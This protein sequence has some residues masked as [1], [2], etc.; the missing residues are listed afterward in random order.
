M[1]VGLLLADPRDYTG[2]EGWNM[3]HCVWPVWSHSMAFVPALDTWV[4]P[5]KN[6]LAIA[7]VG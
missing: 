4:F 5:K 7:Q 2:Q 1:W 3:V 6:D